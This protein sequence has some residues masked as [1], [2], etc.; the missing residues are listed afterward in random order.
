M[1]VQD[2]ME[3]IAYLASSETHGTSTKVERV[4][5]HISEIFLVDKFAYKLKR[6]VKLPYLDFSTPQ[7]RLK[8]CKREVELNRRTAPN[9]YLGTRTITRNADG[10]LSMDGTGELVD[11]VVEMVRFDSDLLFDRLAD[12]GRLTRPLMRQTVDAIAHFHSTLEANKSINGAKAIAKVLSINEAGFAISHVFNRNEID[13]LNNAF[14]DRFADVSQRLDRRGDEARIV[15]GHGDLHLRNIC[16]FQNRPTLFDC[17]EFNDDI[18]TVDV[19]YDLSFLLMDLWHR[20]LTAFANLSA[21]RY[22]DISGDA[23]GF[24]LL[25]F[26]MAVRAAVRAHVLATQVEEG[27]EFEAALVKQARTYFDLASGL[28]RQTEPRLIAIGGLSGTGKSTIA[29]AIAPRL[30][31]PPGARILESDSIRKL[32]HGVVPETRLPES[33]YTNEVSERV[34]DI[35]AN[36]ACDLLNDGGSV[37]V[38]A[39]FSDPLC[40]KRIEETARVSGSRFTGIWLVAPADMMRSRLNERRDSTSDADIGILERQIKSASPP[41]DWHFIDATKPVVE[42]VGD[43][44]EYLE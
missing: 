18:A 28:L 24:C 13:S 38:D 5:T 27:S 32:L 19:L 12:R 9:L 15:L 30:A 25:S 17:I 7:L 11:A 4:E 35:A 10:R 2:Q 3:A 1:I 8:T 31:T 21:N 41:Q 23:D 33:A 16:L 37:V 44:L 14:R 36:R 39:V 22:I 40:R 42:I 26:F 29:E 6:A 43:I 20:D 34:Y